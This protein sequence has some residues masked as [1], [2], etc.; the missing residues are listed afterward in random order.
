MRPPLVPLLAIL[1]GAG[2]A[3]GIHRRGEQQVAVQS[4]Y[5]DPFRDHPVWGIGRGKAQN[6]SVGA[7]YGYFLADRCALLAAVTPLRVFDADGEDVRAAE[8]QLGIRAFVLEFHTGS[9]PTALYFEVL[10]GRMWADDPVPPAG[11]EDNWTQDFGTG[12]EWRLSDRTS[13]L[14]GYRLRHFSN[15]KGSG[16]DNPSQN[17]NVVLG[18]LAFTW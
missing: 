18:A 13:L 12:F 1:L 6:W 5:A 2:C 15:G 7:G 9:A 11:T 8:F 16:S 17:E 14:L 3:G 4:T 10:G